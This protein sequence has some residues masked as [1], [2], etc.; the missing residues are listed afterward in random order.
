MDGPIFMEL[1]VTLRWLVGIAATLD[2]EFLFILWSKPNKKGNRYVTVTLEA[3]TVLLPVES[4]LTHPR[5]S[6]KC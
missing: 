4:A 6:A 5:Y 1:L 2:L 3:H